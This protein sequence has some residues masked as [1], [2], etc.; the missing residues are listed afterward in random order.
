MNKVSQISETLSRIIHDPTGGVV[1]LVDN[2]LAVCRDEGL[3]VEWQNKHLSAR[4]IDRNWSES[5]KVSIPDSVF[6]A[7]LARV[8]VLCNA[9]KPGSVTPYGGTTDLVLDS[10]SQTALS[11]AFVNTASEQRL[12]LG[13]RD[14]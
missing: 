9:Q 4:S 1:H 7:I 12:D 6:R 2:L 14:K 5:L 10:D 11:V 13:P 8:A 3:C